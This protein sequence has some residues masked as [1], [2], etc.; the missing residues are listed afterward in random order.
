MIEHLWSLS[1]EEQFYLVWPVVIFRLRHRKQLLKLSFVVIGLVPL[2]RLLAY[3]LSPPELLAADF[4]YRATPFRVD[5]LVMGAV[6]ALLLRGPKADLIRS[7]AKPLL[8]LSFAAMVVTWLVIGRIL[9]SKIGPAWIAFAGF[10]FVD[11]AAAS[12]LVL[13]LQTGSLLYRVLSIRPL[14]ALGRVSYGFYIFHEILHAYYIVLAR[15]VFGA[16]PSHIYPLTAITA[17]LCTLAISLLSF[18]FFETPFLRLKDRF[19]I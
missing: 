6:V 3:F 17:F 13:S 7:K 5:A 9:A 2:L 15:K 4:L 19:T 16:Y 11:L 10:T 18:H 1:V 14:R 8:A 12:L